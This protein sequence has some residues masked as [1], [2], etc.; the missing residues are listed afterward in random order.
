MIKS[1]WTIFGQKGQLKKT[2]KTMGELQ[3]RV[4]QLE[5]ENAT[6]KDQMRPLAS[7]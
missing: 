4:N 3:T 6:L 2:Y 1:K 7:A 5:E